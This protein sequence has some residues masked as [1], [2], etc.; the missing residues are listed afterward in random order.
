MAGLRKDVELIFRGTDRAS[1][2]IKGVRQEVAGLTVAIQE[3]VTAA[4]KGEGSVDDLAKAYRTLQAAQ[5]D[6][7]EIAKL[8][9]AYDNLAAKHKE[10][11]SKAEEAAQKEQQLAAQVAAAENPTKRLL[12]QREA[13]ARAASRAAEKEK[14]LAAQVAELLAP[15]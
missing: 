11:A 4:Q 3:Q 14:S 7:T 8:A 12:G 5:G 10:A 15:A 9:T 1:P 13:A 2:M 6:V